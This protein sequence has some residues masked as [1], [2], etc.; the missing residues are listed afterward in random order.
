VRP[1]SYTG[2]QGLNRTYYLGEIGF[3]FSP[4]EIPIALR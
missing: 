4:S 1:V 2:S 3:I